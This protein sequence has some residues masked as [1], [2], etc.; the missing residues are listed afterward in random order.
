LELIWGDWIQAQNVRL[1]VEGSR[2]KIEEVEIVMG[3]WI[4]AQECP[5]SS[6]GLWT[7]DR[8]GWDFHEETR[9]RLRNV[10]L[11]FEGSGLKIEEVG[12]NM[13]RLDTASGMF[14]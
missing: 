10:Q 11:A 2:L 5:A 13:G 1:A 9:Y 12:I 8:R 7:Q 3:D 6:R 4:Q 14:S